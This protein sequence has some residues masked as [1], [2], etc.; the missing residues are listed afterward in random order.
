MR[1]PNF[2]PREA[3]SHFRLLNRQQM[4]LYKISWSHY[5]LS[6]YCFLCRCDQIVHHFTDHP[7][8]SGHLMS[9]FRKQGTDST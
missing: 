8:A 6:V 1:I 2:I 9:D 3:G 4:I 5:P 7:E